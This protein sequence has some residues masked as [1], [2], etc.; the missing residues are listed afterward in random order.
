[1]IRPIIRRDVPRGPRRG[2]R[3]EEL[4]RRGGSGPL[5]RSL[6]FP[7][8]RNLLPE[9]DDSRIF[10]L[11]MI[12]HA[13]PVIAPGRRRATS[14]DVGRYHSPAG[15]SRSSCRPVGIHR[16]QQYRTGASGL[17]DVTAGGPVPDPSLS[18]LSL[19]GSSYS[20]CH[21]RPA[22]PLRHRVPCEHR[23]YFEP[24]LTRIKQREVFG[25]RTGTGPATRCC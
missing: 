22:R 18:A 13:F 17:H 1:M 2:R 19:R 8:S 3:S 4:E 14:D 10:I 21:S 6:Q 15:R 5:P 12:G 20:G 25:N 7:T 11:G 23:G 16:A 24:P 9:R